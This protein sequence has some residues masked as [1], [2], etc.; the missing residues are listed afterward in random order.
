MVKKDLNEF[1]DVI[2]GD[3]S[4]AIS[5]TATKL[6][7]NVDVSVSCLKNETG[8]NICPMHICQS[9]QGNEIEILPLEN[10]AE[11]NNVHGYI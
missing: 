11:G 8:R 5:E 4:T 1:V 10:Y 9:C 6:E 3:T 7:E 2:Q